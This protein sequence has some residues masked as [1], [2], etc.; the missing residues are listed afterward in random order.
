[1]AFMFAYN[2]SISTV[3]PSPVI[4]S[5]SSLRAVSAD[6]DRQDSVYEYYGGKPFHDIPHLPSSSGTSQPSAQKTQP[7]M[8]VALD[9]Q[10]ASLR[11]EDG[12]LE[13]HYRLLASEQEKISSRRVTIQECLSAAEDLERKLQALQAGAYTL[14]SHDVLS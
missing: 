4:T 1:M 5:P 7:L 14:T 3:P 13:Q 6:L 10:V 12:E 8:A 9:A 11:K 2:N